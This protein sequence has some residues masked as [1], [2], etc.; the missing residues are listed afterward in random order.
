MGS[1]AT[2]DYMYSVIA[3][4]VESMMDIFHVASLPN[5]TS[6]TY[7]KAFEIAQA[8]EAAEQNALDLESSKS[9]KLHHGKSTG[10]TPVTSRKPQFSACYRCGGKH[11]SSECRFKDVTCHNCGKQGHIAKVCNS[12]AKCKKQVPPS[13]FD[14]RPLT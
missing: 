8:M 6:C 10:T 2:R 11:R 12:K 9:E 14:R 4:Y 5:R 3:S 1:S 7:K 13:S